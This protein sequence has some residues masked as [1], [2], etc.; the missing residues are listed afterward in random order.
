MSESDSYKPEEDA[1]FAEPYLYGPEYTDEELGQI[2]AETEWGKWQQV[3][4]QTSNQWQRPERESRG[5]GGVNVKNLREI[6]A[7]VDRN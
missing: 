2:E 6:Q 5:T 4:R 3:I 7:N 1:Y